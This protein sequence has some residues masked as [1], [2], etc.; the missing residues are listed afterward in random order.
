MTRGAQN[1]G[2]KERTILDITDV[3]NLES[4]ER[5]ALLASI[6]RT[7]QRRTLDITRK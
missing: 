3:V 4:I 2:I 7:S 1:Q 5:P 6:T